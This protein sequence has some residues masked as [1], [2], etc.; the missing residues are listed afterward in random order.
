MLR[1]QYAI[2]SAGWYVSSVFHSEMKGPVLRAYNAYCKRIKQKPFTLAET[3]TPPPT[4][5]EA[6]SGFSPKKP[7]SNGVSPVPTPPSTNPYASILEEAELLVMWMRDWNV[8]SI[9]LSRT[10]VS[11]S[12]TQACNG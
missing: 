8:D 2:K 4:Q 12:V 11:G 1:E 7:P 3:P 10:G 5:A 9:T 6:R